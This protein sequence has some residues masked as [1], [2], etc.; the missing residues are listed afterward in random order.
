MVGIKVADQMDVSKISIHVTHYRKK[1][2]PLLKVKKS[3]QVD[4]LT[5]Q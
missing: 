2:I 4:D 5:Q 1:Y 3:K